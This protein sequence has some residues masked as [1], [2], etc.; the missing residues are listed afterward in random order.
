MNRIN[1]PGFTSE[2]SLYKTSTP[3]SGAATLEALEVRTKLYLQRATGPTG[4]IGFPGQN[5]EGACW[6]MCMTNFGGVNPYFARCMES[7]QASCSD[8]PFGVSSP[9]LA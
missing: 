6:H 5:C 2:A 8:L 3:Y 4:P 7:C 1:I 9:Y